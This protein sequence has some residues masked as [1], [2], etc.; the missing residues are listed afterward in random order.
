MP[1]AKPLK[2]RAQVRLHAYT[3]ETVATVVL[4]EGK[5]LFPGKTAFVEFKLADPILLLPGDRFVVRQLSPVVT[6]GGGSILDT[7]TPSRKFDKPE[8]VKFLTTL[9]DG[10]PEAVVLARIGRRGVL[11][12]TIVDLVAETGWTAPRLEN[13]VKTLLGRKQSIVRAGEPLIS[14][15]VSVAAGSKTAAQL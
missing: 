4:L 12:L 5:Q 8:S 11:G 15:K 9:H 3:A 13:L 2:D 10:D 14:A 7:S 6:I 1:S